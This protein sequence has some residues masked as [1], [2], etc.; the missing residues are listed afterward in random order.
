MQHVLSGPG[1][2][3]DR[4]EPVR[5]DIVQLARDS[6]ALLDRGALGVLVDLVLEHVSSCDRVDRQAEDQQRHEAL[7]QW[8]A[9]KHRRRHRREHHRRGRN[10]LGP[11]PS[12]RERHRQGRGHL[13]GKRPRVVLGKQ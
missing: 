9:R 5:D 2:D 1:L 4:A 13:R 6:L 12:K 8:H 10:P 3:G 7:G 11:A